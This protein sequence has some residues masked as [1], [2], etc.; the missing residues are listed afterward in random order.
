MNLASTDDDIA[1]IISLEKLHGV[2]S[3]M[4]WGLGFVFDL[5]NHF[6]TISKGFL[7]FL[8]NSITSRHWRRRSFLFHFLQIQKMFAKADK[9]GDGKLICLQEKQKSSKCFR[10]ID[11]R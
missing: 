8:I 11:K 4:I 2:A 9:D 5:T 10:I 6:Q 7:I 3:S 1:F